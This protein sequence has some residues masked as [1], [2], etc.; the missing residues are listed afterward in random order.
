MKKNA[1]TRL[2]DVAVAAGVSV[3]TASRVLSGKASAYRISHATE[4]AVQKAAQKLGF[5]PSQVAR[6]L[7]LQKT[8]TI[9]VVVPDMANP[10]FAAIAREVTI[11]AETS[12]RVV[13]MA[14][15][16]DTTE[17]ELRCVQQL[18]ARQVEGL[19]V[20][21][22][23]KTDTHL[24]GVADAGLPL[25]LVDRVFRNSQFVSVTSAHSRGAGEVVDLLTACGHRGIG[26]LQG[27]P[28]TLP[29]EERI[30]GYREALTRR[31][32]AFDSS[33]I[34]G[35]N[36]SAASGYAA[37]RSLLKEREDVTALF[38][39]SNQNVFGALKALQELGRRVPDDISL[40]TFDDHPL[41]DH[42]AVPLTAASQDAQTLGSTAARLLITQ[43]ETGE[44]PR[45]RL[46]R[47][48][49][50]LVERSSVRSIQDLQGFAHLD[51]DR[52]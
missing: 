50:R 45:K 37:S 3:S 52:T 22:V 41:F 32:I 8:H 20:C 39:F 33:L 14:D 6:S 40:V 2:Q 38:A 7:R 29:N 36:F 16:R 48:S 4:E 10:F 9:G 27:L 25:V 26:V 12:G 31:G 51:H 21:P 43:I 11:A 46:H 1:P 28:Q 35:E 18:L 30:T 15:S 44:R 24:A 19:L 23:G 17:Q 13:L 42:L 34:Q 47:V 5:R 49:I